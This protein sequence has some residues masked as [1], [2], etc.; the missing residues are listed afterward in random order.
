MKRTITWGMLLLAMLIASVAAMV[1]ENKTEKTHVTPE[2]PAFGDLP[3]NTYDSDLFYT[4]NGFIRYGDALVGIDVSAHQGDIDWQS[5]KNAGVDFAIIRVGY[6]GYTSGGISMDPKFSQ[7]L[8]GA[9]EEGL[10]VGAYFFSQATTEMEAAEEAAFALECLDDAKLDLPV[11]YD[12]EP[13]E[14]EARTDDVT[15]AQVTKFAQAFCNVITDAGY[16]AGVYFNESM[17]YGFL[18]LS[19]LADYDFWL[20]QYLD[21]PDFYYDFAMWQYSSSGEVPGIEHPVDL[22]LRFIK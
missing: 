7:N 9:K 5:V 4:E 18:D 16:E 8:Q 1:S 17:G 10:S 3:R 20:A 22:N 14:T 21:A 15:G 12:W 11:Y 13:V 2:L 19:E 6:R